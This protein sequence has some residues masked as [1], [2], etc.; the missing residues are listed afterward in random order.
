[1]AGGL[2]Y[3]ILIV[4][5]GPNVSSRVME[6]LGTRSDARVVRLRSGSYPLARRV[7]AE[8]SDSE[9]LSFLDDDDELLPDTLHKKI[10]Y[11]REHP[12]IDVLVTDGLR[13][14]GSVVS[15]VFPP[16]E[17]RSADLIES[18]MH[19]GW[20]AGAIT[21]RTRNIDLKAFDAEF[22]HLEW[23]LTTLELVRRHPV[24][25]L[26]EPMYSYHEDTP[27]SLWK[28]ADH[29]LAGPALWRRLW[30]S[31]AGTRWEPV[32]RKRHGSMCH[33]AS[34]ELARR[35]HMRAAW[36]FH[37]Q[38][39]RSSQSLAY[40]SFTARLVWYSCRGVFVGTKSSLTSKV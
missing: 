29:S 22:R 7:G 19:A 21:L 26:D 3:S 16:V 38:S 6:W 23:T 12:E 37:L 10:A 1:M 4:A 11:F 20:N 13:I 9:F 33:I 40:L 36:R 30:R 39:M 14:N 32:V 8:M 25:F 18:L 28:S 31:Y 5:N 34:S 24:G 27:N 17:T 35:G 15:K 2:P